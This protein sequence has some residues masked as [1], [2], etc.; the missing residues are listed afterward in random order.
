MN[1]V[2]RLSRVNR[3]DDDLSVV[4][5]CRLL[6]VARSTLYWRPTVVSEDDLR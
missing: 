6:K 5:R 4:A 1:H 2:A 3:T